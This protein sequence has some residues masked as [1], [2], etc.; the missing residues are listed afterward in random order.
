VTPVNFFNR[1][2]ISDTISE[3]QHSAL[4]RRFRGCAEES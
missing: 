4:L 3:S 2:L 1:L